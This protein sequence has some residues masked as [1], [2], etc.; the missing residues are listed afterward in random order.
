[1]TETA[2]F[3]FDPADIDTVR[4]F[5]EDTDEPQTMPTILAHV[6][7]LKRAAITHR[8]IKIFD[9]RC[10]YDV[11]DLILKKY[12]ETLRAGK[13]R[14]AHVTED[15]LLAVVDKFRHSVLPCTMLEVR[16]EGTGSFRLH[17]DFLTK[18]GAKLLIPCGQGEAPVEPKYV[19][20]ALDPRL[21]DQEPTPEEITAFTTRVEQE[22]A[23]S[24]L[25]LH[26]EK[27]WFLADRKIEINPGIIHRTE[28]LIKD[29]GVS[30][31]TEDILSEIFST[32]TGDVKFPTFAIS[33][34][35]TLE[36]FYRKKFVCVSLY[37]WGRW[38]L[39][40]N[41]E[42]KKNSIYGLKERLE[43][44]VESIAGE[45]EI[46]SRK[47]E[48]LVLPFLES[49]SP[50]SINM[51]LA[52]RDI[53]A[54]ALRPVHI[55]K[56]F[57]GEEREI[58]VTCQDRRFIID[59]IPE[60]QL[61]MGFDDLFKECRQADRVTLNREESGRFVLQ[62]NKADGGEST[63]FKYDERR[64]LIIVAP[65]EHRTSKN[66]SLEVAIV[67]A[68]ELHKTE[69]LQPEIHRRRDLY[70]A[71]AKLFHAL[72][73]AKKSYPMNILKL[74][75]LLDALAFVPWEKFLRLLL[76]Y[77]A[78]FQQPEDV[79]EAIYR[80][81]V[82]KVSFDLGARTLTT[83]ASTKPAVTP[84][85]PANVEIPKFGLFAEKLQAALGTEPKDKKSG[86]SHK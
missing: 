3:E 49:T 24:P 8:R 75:H 21:K 18:T 19:E 35:H 76:S 43:D 22:V 2:K 64:D 51:C 81:D 86:K 77:P 28:K 39:W 20:E 25:F 23:M 9:P 78:F 62:F 46:L 83:A 12:D 67:G 36:N 71:V 30:L 57:F 4:N 72:G 31:S 56:G 74:Y 59:Y 54:G 84:P 33:F 41:I 7:D 52:F 85:P 40:E 70:E 45:E 16:Y 10:E 11:G 47:R 58:P 61:L 5:F 32:N 48:R 15:V 26:W 53:G 82:T 14:T 65:E 27:Y 6:L 42:T 69:P 34:N 38:N 29:R 66:A 68:E 37:D 63:G 55:A 1:M 73:D 79:P 80:L 50:D 17:T 44:F 60:V 13:T